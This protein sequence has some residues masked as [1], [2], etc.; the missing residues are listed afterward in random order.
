MKTEEAK[1][2]ILTLL[3]T[4]QFTVDGLD[5]E[6]RGE[7]EWYINIQSAQDAVSLIGRNGDVLSALQYLIKNIFRNKDITEEGEHIK[8]D[9]DSYR[10]RQESNVLNMADQR[11][12]EV[13]MTGRSALLPPMSPF[14]RR[15]VHLYVCEKYPTLSTESRGMGNDRSVCITAANHSDEPEESHESSDIY[16]NLDI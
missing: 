9:V 5:V 12:S 14:F 2:L 6:S 13:V 16:A 3:E 10:L 1:T 15:I 11:A 7:G 8:V 4:A